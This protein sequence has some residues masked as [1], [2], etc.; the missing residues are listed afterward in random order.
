MDF[1]IKNADP[2]QQLESGIFCN[3]V[4]DVGAW[5]G[6]YCKALSHRWK[7]VEEG[8]KFWHLYRK[9]YYLGNVQFI[10]VQEN[11][12]IVVANMLCQRGLPGL[13]RK[14]PISYDYLACCI[15]FVREK[16][17]KLKL[18]VVTPEIGLDKNEQLWTDIK[19][20]LKRKLLDFSVPV[21]VYRKPKKV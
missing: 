21:H 4:N 19:Y 13:R 9:D 17:D 7:Q 15:D 2:V 5:T 18:P 16:A 14:Q 3:I 20:Y 8:Y 1:L 11:P 12:K 6:P 10:E